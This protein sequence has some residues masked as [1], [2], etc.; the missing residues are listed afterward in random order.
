M[1]YFTT[2]IMSLYDIFS[3][4]LNVTSNLYR[5][6]TN[7]FKKKCKYKKGI[8]STEH[9]VHRTGT[10]ATVPLSLAKI[11]RDERIGVRLRPAVSP[12]PGTVPGLPHRGTQITQR[13]S[14]KI[15]DYHIIYSQAKQSTLTLLHIIVH[16]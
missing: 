16:S 8:E 9:D 14:Y 2:N 13:L 3:L 10:S 7:L 11:A 6:G 15:I 1:L 4:I 12:L 5:I